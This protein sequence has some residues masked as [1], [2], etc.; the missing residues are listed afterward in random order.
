VDCYSNDWRRSVLHIC[1]AAK[2]R[3]IQSRNVHHIH[4]VPRHQSAARIRV[5]VREDVAEMTA[6][7][8]RMTLNDKDPLGFYPHDRFRQKKYAGSSHLRIFQR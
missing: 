6:F 8:I 2:R 3:K 5:R 7:T 4:F 1:A